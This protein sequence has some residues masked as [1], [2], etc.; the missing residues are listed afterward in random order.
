MLTKLPHN[1]AECL[2]RAADCEAKAEKAV[3]PV[4]KQSFVDLAGKWRAISDT[5]EYIERVNRFLAKPGIRGD[6]S[7]DGDHASH[8]A[9]G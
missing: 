1:V 3:D 2:Q 8:S 6:A 5:Y 4:A 9:R 7:V